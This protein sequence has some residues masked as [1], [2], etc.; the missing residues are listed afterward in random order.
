MDSR[1]H[2]NDTHLWRFKHTVLFC[3]SQARMRMRNRRV[4]LKIHSW[5][6]HQRKFGALLRNDSSVISTGVRNLD[7][8]KR[9]ALVIRIKIS[10]CATL[11]SK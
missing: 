3:G 2:G 7:V 10:H 8:G 1:S 9:T 11:R 5:V 6:K 4:V